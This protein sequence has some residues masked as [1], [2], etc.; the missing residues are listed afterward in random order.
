MYHFNN[1]PFRFYSLLV[2]SYWHPLP[3][4][5]R[6]LFLCER[7]RENVYMM[8]CTQITTSTIMSKPIQ[9]DQEH[10]HFQHQHTHSHIHM[11]TEIARDEIRSHIPM[12]LYLYMNW[13][14]KTEMY[15]NV[16]ALGINS[17]RQNVMRHCVFSV[18]II[19][20]D[21][22]QEPKLKRIANTS[23][24]QITIQTVNSIG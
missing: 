19:S 9:I 12:Y 15:A 13:S 1:C 21:M 3:S 23:K 16:C 20:C 8:L 4:L 7:S 11:A 17:A 22:K 18:I 24:W 6:W 14:N 2:C 5:Y 10:A